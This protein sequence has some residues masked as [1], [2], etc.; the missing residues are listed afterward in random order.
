MTL[1]G[2][3][4]I[5]L[6]L[7]AGSSV[8]VASGLLARTERDRTL[9]VRLSGR[10]PLLFSIALCPAAQRGHPVTVIFRKRT[11]TAI[12]LIDSLNLEK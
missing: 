4:W 12:A 10:A 1:P 3:L 5:T 9:G 11:P 6:E 2:S 8:V 7:A